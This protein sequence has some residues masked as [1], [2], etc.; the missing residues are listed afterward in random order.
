MKTAIMLA[1]IGNSELGKDNKS[2]FKPRV[3]DVYEKSKEMWNSGDYKNLELLLLD[4]AIEKI[5]ESFDLQKIILFGTKQVEYNSQ[6][7]IYISCIVKKIICNRYNLDEDKVKILKVPGDP[8]DCKSLLR[9]YQ[10]EVKKIQIA[11]DQIFVSTTGGTQQEN[12]SLMLHIDRK[13]RDN[14]KIVYKPH[15]ENGTKKEVRISDIFFEDKKEI[16]RVG[17]VQIAFKMTKTFPPK[18]KDKEAT[19][20]KVFKALDIAY[21]AEV[22]IVCLP[23]LCMCEEWLK[24]IENRYPDMIII[25][26]SYY[27]EERHNVC[28]VIMD[29]DRDILP[30]Q[31][32]ITPSDFENPVGGEGMV[33][34]DEPVIY[35]ETP[36][37]KFSVL[38]CRDFANCCSD[39]KGK[40]DMVFVPAYNPANKRFHEKAHQHVEDSPSYVIIS[41]AAKFGGT[42][43]FGRVKNTFFPGLVNMGCKQKGDDSFK[44]CELKKKEEGIIIAD[45]NLIHKSFLMPTPI[46]TEEDIKPVDKISKIIF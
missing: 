9:F 8:T 40:V 27:D 37:G 13:F 14:V 4:P 31:L 42:S 30:P 5:N 38:I 6:D 19:R 3:E 21:E 34:G 44:L 2:I 7:T 35:E 1:N 25:A 10:Q 24:E 45:F 28:H 36:F 16:A 23:E 46:N 32:K 12:L 18:I 22:D 15:D 11:E 39:L 33:S 20:E 29:S 17:V 43:I 26:G 41:N